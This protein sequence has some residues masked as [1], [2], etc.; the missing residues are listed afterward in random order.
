M[1]T[2]KRDAGVSGST[3]A[4]TDLRI[5]RTRKLLWEALMDLLENRTFESLSI[6]EICDTAMVHRTTFYKHF[7]DK[8]HLLSYGL[9]LTDELFANKSLE[10]RLLH[11]M[12]TFR[13]FGDTKPFRT[14]MKAAEENNFLSNMMMKHGAES[15]KRDL[16][17]ARKNGVLF[18]IPIEIL[19]AFYSGAVSSLCSWWMENGMMHSPEEIDEYLGRMINRELF[20][21]ERG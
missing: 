16:A 10:E 9:S 14:L 19:A 7:E 2:N 13:S 4:K 15:L 17:E 1:Y 18:D 6:Q 8:Y 12:K 20:S 21:P 3:D 5:R 11:P